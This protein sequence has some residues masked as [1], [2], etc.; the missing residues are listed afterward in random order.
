MDV[1][2]E[3][4]VGVSMFDEAQEIAVY[5]FS[6]FLSLKAVVIAMSVILLSVLCAVFIIWCGRK[7]LRLINSDDEHIPLLM[8]DENDTL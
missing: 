1:V 7:R 8:P 6:Y 3:T 2:D 5:F 4:I